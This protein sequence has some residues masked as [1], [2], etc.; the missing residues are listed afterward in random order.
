MSAHQIP[1]KHCEYEWQGPEVIN[2]PNS[3]NNTKKKNLKKIQIL[4]K[5]FLNIF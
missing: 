3:D 1:H 5:N 2:R 4:L